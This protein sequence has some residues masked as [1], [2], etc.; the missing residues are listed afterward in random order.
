MDALVQTFAAFGLPGI[1]FLMAL[2]SSLF[3]VPSELV[4]IPAGYLAFQG[5]YSFVAAVL[6][7]GL[8]SVV[9]AWANY[10]FGRYIGKTILL[11]YGKYFFITHKKY[12]LAEKLFE[13]ND[14]LYTFIGRFLP[15][16]RHLISIPA[17][18]FRMSPTW[19]TGLTFVGATMWC[20]VL[21]S[22]GYFIGPSVLDL[23]RHYSHE[24]N[25]VFMILIVAG[26]IWFIRKK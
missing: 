15:V 12:E 10:L 16:V 5:Q 19:F 25:I 26:V 13:K 23:I 22:I 21:V 9:G 18:I 3:P 24:A 8:G 1:F 2:E 7:G 14:K 6:A 20:G 17:G 4:M 11:K